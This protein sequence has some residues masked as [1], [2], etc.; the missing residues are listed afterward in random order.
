MSYLLYLACIRVGK[1]NNDLATCLK[2]GDHFAIV[3]EPNNYEKVYFFILQS[4]KKLHIVKEDS[5]P[6]DFGNYVEKGN[7]IVIG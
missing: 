2:F 6:N 4:V 3:A 5:R 1:K 7:E